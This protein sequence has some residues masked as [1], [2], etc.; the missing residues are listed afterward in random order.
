[1]IRSAIFLMIAL[2]AAPVAA[3]P[4]TPAQ[5]AEIDR[6]AADVLKKT[7]VPSASIAVVTDGTLAYAKAYGRQRLAP[8]APSVT[9][10][11]P[12]AS[13]SKQFTAAAIL[14]LAEEGRLSLDDKVAK[15]LPELTDA[16]KVTIR[17]LLSHTSGYRD[18][19]PQDFAFAA[20]RSP[21]KPDAILARWAKA[22]LDYAP[23]S[24]WQYSNTGY[25]AA[26]R[27][28][29]IASGEPLMAFLQAHI[30]KP[31]GMAAIDADYGLTK[32]DA[33][34]FT[35]YAL[36][37]VRVSQVPAPGW[38]WAAGQLAT[39]PSE[40]AKWDIARIRRTVLKPESWQAQEGEIK[41]TDGSGS[42]YGLGVFVDSVGGHRRIQ[43]DGAAEGYLTVNRVYPDER[44]AIIVTVN[45]DFGNAQSAIA[46]RI[47]A[48]LV[49]GIDDVAGGRA[50]FD[51]LRSGT[52]DRAHFTENGNFYFTDR[53]LADY[54]DSLAPLG[55]PESIV[56]RGPVR[57]RGGLTSESFLIS[58][59]D[60]KLVAVMRT[61]PASKRIEEFAIYPF[62]N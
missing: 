38:L 32:A 53:V 45:A 4:L 13:V 51:A 19:W 40:L 30:L 21:V 46:D 26:G 37:P 14:L 57:L 23:G 62:S 3:T 18:Y 6:I 5:R 20:M 22:P 7:D 29:E 25:V 44:A 50:V 17:Q 59:P 48:M 28:V 61:D 24:K 27:I 41:L 1:M 8:S 58:Y 35:R 31:A 34:G 11:Y 15:Y 33:A 52:I 36:G 39:T 43:H 56:R 2:V 60:R 16:D 49:G 12:I 9:A 55:P 10:R 47:E 54:R 42:G